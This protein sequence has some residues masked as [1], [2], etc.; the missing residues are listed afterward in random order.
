LSALPTLTS[1]IASTASALPGQS[2][3]FSATVSDLFAGGATPNE[4]TVTFSDQNEAIDSATLVDGMATFTTSS[5]A[6]GTYTVTA[7]YSGT[8]DFAASTTGTI[9]TAAGNG[10][11]GY[12]GDN[13]PPTAAEL[14]SPGGMAV[15]SAGDLFIA[16]QD[17]NVVRE[18]VAATGDII[19]VAGNGK[20]G[21]SG[22]NGPA[23]DAEMNDPRDVAVDSAG[24]LFIADVNNNRIREVV[25]ATGDIITVAGNGTDAY[26]GDNGPATAAEIDGATG[27]AVDSTGDL[28]IGEDGDDRVREVVKATGDIITDAGNGTDGYSGDNGPATAAELDGSGRVAVDSVGHVFI[29]GNNASNVVR[30]TMPAVTVIISPTPTPTPTPTRIPTPTP[31]PTTPTPT[32]TPT[33]SPKPPPPPTPPPAPPPL[34]VGFLRTPPEIVRVATK[35]VDRGPEIV[36]QLDQGIVSTLALKKVW[37]SV[38]TTGDDGVLGTSDSQH[39][40]VSR[41]VYQAR[42]HTITLVMPKRPQVRGNVLLTVDA[43][44]IVNLLGRHLEGDN[45]V[46]GVNFV[47]EVDLP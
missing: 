19:T 8:A 16:D 46:P 40:P 15:D 47:R 34:P 13:D 30:E 31:T 23:T 17:N 22:D 3:T 18:V 21:Y 11:A 14:N 28:F 25:A 12:T 1:L 26:R 24:D 41:V 42:T 5:L 38:E 6:A 44:G 4:G 32:P 7:S 10:K 35:M 9:A 20:A 27:I 2:V 45:V 29:A 36:L 33:P 43:R 39:V 37:Y